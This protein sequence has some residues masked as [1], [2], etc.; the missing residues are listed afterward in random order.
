MEIF[1]CKYMLIESFITFLKE[2]LDIENL[3]VYVFTRLTLL[4]C[5]CT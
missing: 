3:L 1:E 5:I 2:L 4:M